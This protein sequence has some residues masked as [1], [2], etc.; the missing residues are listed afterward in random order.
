VGWV[1]LRPELGRCPRVDACPDQTVQ[2]PIALGLH[3][4]L[5][6]RDVLCDVRIRGG[7]RAVEIVGTGRTVAGFRRDAVDQSL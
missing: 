1:R 7:V 5:Y 2:H 6:Y 4:F 3:E